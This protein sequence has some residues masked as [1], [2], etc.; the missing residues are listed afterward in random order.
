LSELGAGALDMPALRDSLLALQPGDK[1]EGFHVESSLSASGERIFVLNARRIVQHDA[2]LLALSD[3]TDAKRAERAVELAEHGFREMLMNAPQAITMTDGQSSIVFANHMA[4]ETFG[5]SVEELRMFKCELL[6]PERL[7]VEYNAQLANFRRYPHHRD[8]YRDVKTLGLR[9]D[10]S[11]FPAMV[12]LGAM[13][14][15]GTT[16]VVSFITDITHHH[17]AE[18]QIRQYQAQLQRMAFDAAVTEERERRRIAADLH[19]GIGQT[20]AL[21]QIKLTSMRDAATDTTRPGMDEVIELLAKSVLDTRTLT[22]ELSPPMLY[23]LGLKDALSWLAEEVEKRQG[24]QIEL[25]DD[26]APKALDESTAALVYRAVRELIMNVF[27]HSKSTH[28]KVSLRRDQDDLEIDVSDAGVGFASG[29]S[30][31]QSPVGG[32]GL[33]NVREQISRLGGKMTVVS[34]PGQGTQVSL[35]VPMR[36]PTQSMQSSQQDSSHE[37]SDRRRP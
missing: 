1:L 15:D 9:K 8:A 21:A 19:D 23:D 10:G 27:K 20:L 16:Q 29:E 2:I 36:Q 26:D 11:E 18:R 4:A 5:Y 35:R 7:R 3:T 28:A 31:T 33:F 34:A 30:A 25:S 12:N 6:L 22:F 14:R 13:L 24:I 37:S 32:F 17:V